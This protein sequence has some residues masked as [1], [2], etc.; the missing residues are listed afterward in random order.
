[1]PIEWWFDMV[2]K[3][4]AIAAVLELGALLWMNADRNR[5]IADLKAET[6]KV[7]ALAERVIVIAAE[8]KTFLF[9]ERKT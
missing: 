9:N 1:M 6:A 3:G 7:E 8:L 5:L 2:A 4:G